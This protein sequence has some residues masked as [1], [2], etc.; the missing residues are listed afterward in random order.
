MLGSGE[1]GERSK[2]PALTVTLVEIQK[3]CLKEGRKIRER[4]RYASG[5]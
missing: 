2:G 5:S 3:A 4:A 1:H